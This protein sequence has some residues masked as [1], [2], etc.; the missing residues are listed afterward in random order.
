MS[1]LFDTALK[2]KYKQYSANDPLAFAKD[3]IDWSAFPPLLKDLYHNDTDK[4]GRPNIPIITMVKVLYLQSLYNLA[5]E[6]AETLIRDRISLMN[7]LDYPDILPDAKTIWYFRERLS[8]TGRD[9]II[10]NELQRQLE[11]KGIRVK[12]GSAQDATF[13]TS[14]PGHE[15]HE[16][17][18]SQGKTR[19]SKDGSFTKKN[20]KTFF[21]YKG[22]SIVDDNNPV[23]VIRSYAVT[24]AKGHDTRI[25]LSKRGI[26]VYRDKGYFGS[27]PKGIDGTMDRSVRNHK[28]SI[29][30][31]RRNRRISRKRSM[32]EYPYAV[33]KRVFHFSHV[34]V[35]LV[36]RVR[37][38]FMFACFGYNVH[39][40][41]IVQG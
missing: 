8:K 16:E 17:P 15:K 38:K 29:E 20:N 37:V 31:V 23:P 21:G 11:S 30:S 13:I 40:L 5:D 22:H 34:M 27:D 36:R 1:D 12:K 24:T 4:G 10:W 18:R 32:V 25:D 33:M 9:R 28:L 41:N 7:F 6:Q 2:E 35:T 19:R 14:D 3:V 26:T 39:A